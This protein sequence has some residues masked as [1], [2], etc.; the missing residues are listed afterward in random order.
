M[1]HS[2]TA[3]TK[4]RSGMAKIT[5]AKTKATLGIYPAKIFVVGGTAAV[6]FPV[7]Q[8]RFPETILIALDS[9]TGVFMPGQ[10]AVPALRSGGDCT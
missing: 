6:I 9:G 2:M 7:M 4:R 10:K 8:S 3:G 1:K 5:G